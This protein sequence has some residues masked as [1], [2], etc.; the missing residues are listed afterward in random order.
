MESTPIAI[1]GSI[2]ASAVGAL[3]WVI[4]RKSNGN[5]YDIHD[6]VI[7]ICAHVEEKRIPLPE[8]WLE[9]VEERILHKRRGDA[10]QFGILATL[11]RR[12]HVNEA[13]E[14]LEMLEREA[15]R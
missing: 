9:K 5:G 8:N 4:K 10:M 11:L 6:L 13:A 7:K 14:L 2:A 3:I 1:L 12:G 15:K